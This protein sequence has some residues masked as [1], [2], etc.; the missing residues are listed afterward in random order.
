MSRIR[1]IA[2]KIALGFVLVGTFLVVTEAVLRIPMGHRLFSTHGVLGLEFLA[3]DAFHGLDLVASTSALGVGV[4]SLGHRGAELDPARPRRIVTMGDSSTFGVWVERPP[5]GVGESISHFDSY[6]AELQVLLDESGHED[7]QVINTGVPGS[8]SSH[9]M[10]ILLGEVLELEPDIVTLRVGANEHAVPDTRWIGDPKSPYW[11]KL[12]YLLGDLRTFQAGL[13]IFERLTAEQEAGFHISL[14]QFADDLAEF[15]RL[16]RERGFHLV[17][18]DYPL[19]PASAYASN[20]GEI[21][22]FYGEPNLD[23]MYRTHALY[24]RTLRSVAEREGV[25]LLI[26]APVLEGSATP[27]FGSSFMHPNA[28]GMGI[29]A[30]LLYD[31][32]ASAG[33][34]DKAPPTRPTAPAR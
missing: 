22:L 25:A 10:R 24:Q 9:S 18:L 29:T 20:S 28:T 16:G 2:S 23:S 27:S 33:W 26:T 8:H 11:R 17:L 30:E 1:G 3:W 13:A 6:P 34:L 4:N 32:F 21:A 19:G 12:F 5:G 31:Y 14:Q 7:W 15:A